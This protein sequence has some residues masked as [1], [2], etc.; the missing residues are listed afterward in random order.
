MFTCS[1]NEYLVCILLIRYNNIPADVNSKRS[2]NVL[3]SRNTLY[4]AN[5]GRPIMEPSFR[6]GVDESDRLFSG[7]LVAPSA[8][9][10]RRTNIQYFMSYKIEC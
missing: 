10:S 7:N 1:P 3:T 6:L 9:V 8:T 4:L 5:V 2:N